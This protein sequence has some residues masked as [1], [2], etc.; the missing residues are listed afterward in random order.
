LF[1]KITFYISGVLSGRAVQHAQEANHPGT[2]CTV[3]LT[4][5]RPTLLPVA[6]LALTGTGLHGVLAQTHATE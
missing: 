2:V 1:H 3:A 5:V 6:P 4:S